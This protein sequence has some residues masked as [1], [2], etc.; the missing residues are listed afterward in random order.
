MSRL[1]I[2]TKRLQSLLCDVQ[3]KTNY[4]PE[5]ISN[6]YGMAEKKQCLAFEA[7]PK[8]GTICVAPYDL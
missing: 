1:Q 3:V 4:L 8:Y 2:A 5:I 6:L 7:H